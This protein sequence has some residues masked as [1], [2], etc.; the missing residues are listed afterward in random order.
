MQ[1]NYMQEREL[2][3]LLEY[4]RRVCRRPDGR[5]VGQCAF[6]SRPD[7]DLQRELI[8]AGALV[9]RVDNM[10]GSIVVIT[11]D[12]YSYFPELARIEQREIDQRRHERNMVVLTGVFCVICLIVGFVLGFVLH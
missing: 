2:H 9:R 12:G 7:N 5:I 1:L 4:E 10:R 3:R 8:A 6:P 11:S